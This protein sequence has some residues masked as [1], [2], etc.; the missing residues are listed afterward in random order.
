MQR[1]MMNIIMSGG[2]C[3]ETCQVH[4]DHAHDMNISI[5]PIQIM[6]KVSV[7]VN[8]LDSISLTPHFYLY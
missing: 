8:L 5:L 7:A 6:T 4:F 3:A 1:E 2:R